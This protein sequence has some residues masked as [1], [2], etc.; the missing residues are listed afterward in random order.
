[1]G[2]EKI[3]GFI[4]KNFSYNIINNI[5]LINNCNKILA[6][7]IFFDFNFIIYINLNQIE[8]E[9]N[10]IIKIIYGLSFTPI[11]ILIEQLQIILNKDHWLI[12][13]PELLNI[14]DGE[15]E[16][17][18]IKDFKLFLN[19]KEIFKT[20]INMIFEDYN[21][22]LI[23]INLLF[24]LKI[25]YFI[26][27]KLDSIHYIEFIQNIFIFFDGIPSYA[28]ILEQKR[29]RIKNYL[30]SNIRKKIFTRNFSKMKNNIYTENGISFNYFEW[31]DNKYGIDKSFGPSSK[32]IINL[33]FFLK[34]FYKKN[35]LEDINYNIHICS[36]KIYGESD[37]K[38]FKYISKKNIKDNIYI[39]TCDSDLVH[40][41]L[42]QQCY[43]NIFQKNLS[44]NIIRY[45]S[46]ELNN[47][48]HI[49]A[50]IIIKDIL[51]IIKKIYN[52]DDNNYL[53]ILDFLAI[54]YF[55]GNDYLPQS[56][57]FGPEISFEEILYILKKN[58]KDETIISY[59][60]ENIKINW[61]KFLNFFIELQKKNKI[62]KVKLIR[63]FK[64]PDNIIKFLENNNINFDKF[65][66]IL[67]PN[68]LSYQGSKLK[69]IS[70][71]WRKIFFDKLNIDKNP[72]DEYNLEYKKKINI[73]K[74]LNLWLNYNNINTNIY[75]QKKDNYLPYFNRPIE[76]SNENNYQDMFIYVLNKT[77]ILSYEK[78][79]LYY[80]KTKIDNENEK[81]NVE[82]YL[83][84][85][86]YT[87]N[88]F[89]KD[90]KDY[91]PCNLIFYKYLSVPSIES[92]IRYLS[93][94]NNISEHFDKIISNKLVKKKIILIIYHI[95]YL[96]HLIY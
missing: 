56:Y 68:Y 8:E 65:T 44:Y 29:R 71:D 45:N 35:N 18:I 36:G 72:L 38:I 14:L 34:K 91:N 82:D 12:F 52:T 84:N 51:K 9:I 49:N 80:K 73:E 11:E 37:F 64:T 5:T 66:N 83:L 24:F 74:S 39:H 17:E 70:N 79:N 94:N 60:N 7:N 23:T 1:M 30:E 4:N 89:F 19:S 81:Y 86:Y 21:Q 90:I 32:I 6:E 47:A 77:M 75:N 2:L 95:I 3:I 10:E 42:V 33:E 76:L 61:K 50:N 15:N 58:N 27:N 92:I 46:N 69:D 62:S 31:L 88:S 85:I 54:C 28:K 48:Q 78:N 40:L 55:F 16:E 41:I 53:I 93:D 22:D 96:L 87:I 57:W 59:E 25:Y 63:Y 13:K 67:I 20:K 43:S 26:K